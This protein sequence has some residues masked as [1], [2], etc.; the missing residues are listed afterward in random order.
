MDLHKISGRGV[1]LHT[2]FR[3]VRSERMSID[4]QISGKLAGTGKGEMLSAGTEVKG[5]AGYVAIE[6]VTG[7]LDGRQG[8]FIL[9]HS[10]TMSR[11]VPQLSITVVPDSGTG[12]LAGLIGKFQIAIKE[13]KHFYNF[14]YALP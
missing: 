9:Q 3:A 1:R 14:E 13:G 4:K 5:S 12:E 8:S 7:T 11:G 2:A 6:K 10:G